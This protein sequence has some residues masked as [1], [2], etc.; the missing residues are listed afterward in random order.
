VRRVYLDYNATT[1][2]APSVFE[3]MQPFLVSQ[4]GN[5]S[6]SH[7][8]GRIAAQAVDDAREKLAN[9]LG[10]SLEEVVFTSGGTESNNLAIKGAVAAKGLDTPQTLVISAIEHPAVREPARYLEKLGHRVVTCPVNSQ[11]LVHLEYLAECLDS[12]TTLVS[13]MHANNE[14]GSIQPIRDIVDIC[15]K[16]GILVHSDAA[17]SIGKVRVQVDELGVDLLTI[18]G[19]KMYAPKGVGALFVRRGVRL[20]SLLHGAAH[21]QGL[22]AGTENVPYVVALGAAASLAS[23]ST[24]EMSDRLAGLRDLLCQLLVSAIP[25]PVHVHAAHARRLPNT[26]SISLPHINAHGLLERIPEVC[27]STGAACH[28]GDIAM[29]DTMRAMGVSAQ[30][31]MGTIRFSLGWETSKDEIEYAAR[32]VASAWQSL[33]G[34]S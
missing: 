1:P 27:A 8:L 26:L 16:Q 5:P 22:R 32:S 6:S 13:I 33:A 11:G 34:Q 15:H 2:V 19:H 29:S 28:S 30:V 3:A 17:Q 31:A 23:R 25:E 10:C 14:V 4:F 21:E 7:V 18:A 12:S 9:L 20:E 24:E